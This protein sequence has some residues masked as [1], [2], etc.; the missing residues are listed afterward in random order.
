MPIIATTS[1]TPELRT[2]PRRSVRAR[3][4]ARAF[5]YV[6]KRCACADPARCGHSWYCRFRDQA[7]T[8]RWE[9][10]GIDRRRALA[11]LHEIECE[12]DAGTYQPIPARRAAGLPFADFW[13][14]VAAP[15]LRSRHAANTFTAE[16]IK[17]RVV[18]AS[19]GTLS[20][21]E[22]TR[23][24]IADFLAAVRRRP[25][26]GGTVSGRT[27]NLYRSFLRTVFALAVDR[28]IRPDNPAATAPRFPEPQAARDRV[29]AAEIERVLAAVTPRF[30]A[31][32]ALLKWTGARRGEIAG[33]RWSWVRLPEGVI[34]VPG[35]ARKVGIPVTLHLCARARALLDRLRAARG[36][37]LPTAADGFVFPDLAVRPEA[38]THAWLRARR[39]VGDPRKSG[40]PCR[41]QAVAPRKRASE[42]P[43]AKLHGLRHA[44]GDAL[45]AAGA[46]PA[47]IRDALGHKNVAT[48][49]RYIAGRDGA[50][51]RAAVLGVTNPGPQVRTD[52][53]THVAGAPA[54]AG[55]A[56]Q[57]AGA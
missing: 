23:G 41:G 10:V 49:L 28:G 22:V 38:L 44:I 17:A 12:V 6:L 33:L 37:A 30:Y 13:A 14:S 8:D 32:I 24:H 4:R 40:R 3:H 20:V 5:G 34:E 15:I 36:P 55:G 2:N 52:V 50:A 43:G 1:P 46:S 35:H 25:T 18:A 21:A 29:P 54:P 19:F 7:K 56:A 53:A 47:V 31:P 57:V 26:V 9:A 51:V 16:A 27:A 42:L 45:A 48:T 39:Q 11:R